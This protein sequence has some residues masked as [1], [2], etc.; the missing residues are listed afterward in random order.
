MKISGHSK[1]PKRKNLNFS[2]IAGFLGQIWSAI[3][4]ACG[5]SRD[6]NKASFEPSHHA[7]QLF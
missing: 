2:Y 7:L 5:G 1:L 3:I 6:Q 4:S